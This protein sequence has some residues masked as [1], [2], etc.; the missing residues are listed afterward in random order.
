MATTSY[1]LSYAF[2]ETLH[3]RASKL[4]MRSLPIYI[5]TSDHKQKV[6]KREGIRFTDRLFCFFNVTFILNGRF[7]IRRRHNYSWQ[8]A[9][10][11]IYLEQKYNTRRKILIKYVILKVFGSYYQPFVKVCQ[12]KQNINRKQKLFSHS[13]IQ[14]QS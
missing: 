11:N 7:C 3:D 14:Q 10:I 1:Q 4:F 6:L 5:A 9:S 12:I 8:S 2:V 13:C